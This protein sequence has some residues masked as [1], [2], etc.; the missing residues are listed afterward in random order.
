MKN[1]KGK[2]PWWRIKDEMTRRSF[3]SKNGLSR[4]PPDLQVSVLSP[5]M[6]LKGPR[7]DEAADGCFEVCR[8]S[9]NR[10]PRPRTS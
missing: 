9:L 3:T 6:R 4:I 10:R 7:Q 1:Q 8:N 5:T 2:A